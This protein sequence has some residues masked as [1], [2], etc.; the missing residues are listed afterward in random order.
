MYYLRLPYIQ[1]LIVIYVAWIILCSLYYF[2]FVVDRNDAPK[3]NTL[4]FALNKCRVHSL[5]PEPTILKDLNF[6][7]QLKGNIRCMWESSQPQFYCPDSFKIDFKIIK[8]YLTSHPNKQLRIIGNYEQIE[9]NEEKL[10]D[11]GYKRAQQLKSYFID[12]LQYDPE[13]IIIGSASIDSFD[14]DVY[15]EMIFNA[16]DLSIQDY[17]IVSAPEES[18]LLA[19]VQPIYF[20]QNFSTMLVSD[21]LKQYLIDVVNFVKGKDNFVLN[22]VGNTNDDGSDERNMKLGMERAIFVEIQI[23]NLGI[24]YTKCESK[25]ENN[26]RYDNNTAEGKARN[27]RVDLQIKKIIK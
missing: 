24:I 5:E 6:S 11:L 16:Y 17:H 23:K 9:L 13:R 19:I 18:R 25:G 14:L 12:S 10:G 1:K 15:H 20:S 2:F 8:Q 26:P 27:R 21:S 4:Q 22:I 7:Y 3:D